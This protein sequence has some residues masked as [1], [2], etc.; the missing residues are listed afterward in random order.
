M[1]DQAHLSKALRKDADIRGKTLRKIK[2]TLKPKF[3]EEGNSGGRGG[4]RWGE[5]V[6][7]HPG[8]FKNTDIGV[9]GARLY[10][11]VGS[12]MARD[13]RPKRNELN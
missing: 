9:M 2:R 5:V 6:D 1:P 10:P 3:R 12:V 7:R 13:K 8:D 11:V 4:K